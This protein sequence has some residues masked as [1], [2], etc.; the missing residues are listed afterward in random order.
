MH[1]FCFIKN[2]WLTC[3]KYF[4][5]AKDTIGILSNLSSQEPKR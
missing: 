4:Y 1:V 2:K 5:C 3:S